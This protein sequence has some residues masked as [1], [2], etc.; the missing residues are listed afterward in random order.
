MARKFMGLT[1]PQQAVFEQIAT[2]NDAGHHPKTL[3]SLEAKGFIVSSDQTLGGRFP[4]KIKRYSVPW[5]V[6]YLWCQWCAETVQE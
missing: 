1:K 5:N 4:V 2:G 3:E 6:H